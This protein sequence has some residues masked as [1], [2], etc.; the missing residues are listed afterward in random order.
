MVFDCL[1]VAIVHFFFSFF[2]FSLLL[3]Y[4]F[5]LDLLDYDVL[6]IGMVVLGFS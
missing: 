1:L 4:T 2:Y 3:F 6:I 5:G